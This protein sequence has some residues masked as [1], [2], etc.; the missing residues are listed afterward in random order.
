MKPHNYRPALLAAL[1]IFA[2]FMIYRSVVTSMEMNRVLR[3]SRESGLVGYA[4]MLSVLVHFFVLSMTLILIA[5]VN[6]S[7]RKQNR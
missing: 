3:Y 5:V 2:G 6:R 1:T 4:H 7:R